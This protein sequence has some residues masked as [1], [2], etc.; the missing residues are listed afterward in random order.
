MPNLLILYALNSSGNIVHVDAVPRGKYCG[1]VCPACEAPLVARKG[2]VKAHHFAHANNQP[3]CESAL[4]A[5]AKLMLFQRIQRA[6]EQ[7]DNLP[8]RY[9]CPICECWHDVN[10]LG[11]AQAV[12]LETEIPEA[13]IRPDILLSSADGQPR[14]LIEMVYKHSPDPPVLAFVNRKNVGLLEF[15]IE[16]ADDLDLLEKTPLVPRRMT[17]MQCPCPSCSHC[18]ER[19]CPHKGHR[20]C[21]RCNECVNFDKF[22]DYGP[23]EEHRD[24]PECGRHMVLRDG[25]FHFRRCFCCYI[26]LKFKRRRCPEPDTDPDHGHCKKCGGRIK[27]EYRD[28]YELCYQ[29][30]QKERVEQM[31]QHSTE[32]SAEQKARR[33]TEEQRRITE[34]QRRDAELKNV[35]KLREEERRKAREEESK[36]WADLSREVRDYSEQNPR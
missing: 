23:S 32:E 16:N 29:C 5:T 15:V 2:E 33:Q 8:L 14:V 31:A 36:A 21:K 4:H 11:K 6:I 27:S 12:Y 13:D 9:D 3:A 34:E 19:C 30:Y 28:V 7:G 20:Y 17:V 18:S 22:A 35:R 25:Q 1:C 24:C 10:L 26:A